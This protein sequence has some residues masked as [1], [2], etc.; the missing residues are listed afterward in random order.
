MIS[1]GL[2]MTEDYLML[3]AWNLG[4]LGLVAGRG[5]FGEVSTVAG[6]IRDSRQA[7]HG[8]TLGPV[9]HYI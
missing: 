2:L 7:D 6:R 8:N 3:S 1:Y 9:G 5:V 4:L